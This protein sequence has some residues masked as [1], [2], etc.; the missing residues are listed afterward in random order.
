M[1]C[2]LSVPSRRMPPQPRVSPHRRVRASADVVSPLGSVSA[3]A[4]PPRDHPHA[5]VRE[6][7]L[8]RRIFRFRIV[9]RRPATR[10][11]ARR[12]RARTS[13]DA[14]CSLGS[15]SANTVP[16][17]VSPRA[18]VRELPL[19]RCMLSVPS[20]QTPSSRA[21]IRVPR[22]LP[23][24]RRI[25][26]VPSRRALPPSHAFTRAL[27]ELPLMRCILSVPYRRTSSRCARSS[28]DAV[29]SLGSAS[30]NAAPPRVQRVPPPAV[31]HRRRIWS[32][33]SLAQRMS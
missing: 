19:P 25:L 24:T 2:I 12:L 3:N 27:C 7:P 10:S 16:P 26:S 13:A 28:A 15:R 5:V 17:R 32:R 31:C 11:S 18:A 33:F 21:F 1:R 22:V 23:L 9:E 8:T 6:L 4:A 30:A 20:R 14:V 29:H